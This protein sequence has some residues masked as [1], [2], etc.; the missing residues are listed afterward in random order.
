MLNLFSSISPTRI[1][2]SIIL[3]LQVV[4]L[5]IIYHER[6]ADIHFV[7]FD[8]YQPIQDTA[9]IELQKQAVGIFAGS[10]GYFPTNAVNDKECTSLRYDNLE[11]LKTIAVNGVVYNKG[12]D[13]F[14]VA[15]KNGQKV[16]VCRNCAYYDAL[17]LCKATPPPIPS[18]VSE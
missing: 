2:L 4:V 1:L 8:R 5:L 6:V 11:N 3:L 15:F 18:P 14:W 13:F 16:G 17:Q 9:Y 12:E 10:S 7:G